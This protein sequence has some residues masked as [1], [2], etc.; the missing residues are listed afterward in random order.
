MREWL[1]ALGPPA[2]SDA[3]AALRGELAALRADAQG[4]GDDAAV[5]RLDEAEGRLLLWEQEMR[6]VA[7]AEALVVEAEQLAA[8]TSIDHAKLPDR[9]QALDRSIRTPA[10]T[11]RFEAAL[12][13]IEQRRLAQIHA[14]RAADERGAATR[15]RAA[16]HGRAGARRR[17]AAGGARS[18][19]RDQGPQGRCGLLPKPTVQRLGR[20]L[21]QLTELERWES[22]GQQNA[23]VQLCE[24][25]EAVAA[26]FPEAA[27]LAREVQK[28][29][30]EWKALDQ[31]HAGVPKALWERFDHACEKAYAPAARH[32]AEVA[33]QR[34]QARKQR[35]DFIAAAA[36]HAPTLLTESPDWRAIERWLRETDQAWREGGLG[37]VEPDTWKKLDARLKAALAPLRDA[38]GAARDKA[39]LTRQQL[40]DEATALV[41][42]AMDRDAP[43]QVKA[44]QAR[45]QEHAKTMTLAQR[46][47]R[48]LWEQF[49]AACD[50]VFSAREA[51]RKEADGR[52]GESRRALEA[53]CAELEQLARATDKDDQELRRALRELQEQWKKASGGSEP[54]MQALESRFRNARSAV[55]ATLAARARSR[56]AAVWQTLAAKERLCEGLDALVRS[57]ASPEDAAARVARSARAMDGPAGAAGSVGEE[58]GRPARRRGPRIGRARRGRRLR[59]ADRARHAVAAREAARA[60]NGAGPRQSRGVPGAAARAAGPAAAQPLPG[61]D[62]GHRPDAGRSPAGLV[63]RAGRGRR[64][65]PA[66][67]DT[68]AGRD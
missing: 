61:R 38:L 23:R 26:Q 56:E 6:A 62:Q 54:G 5:S 50:A 11:R 55:D 66:A 41:P 37:S 22:F 32:F 33:A 59:R 27:Q 12:M 67:R 43:S 29:R 13:V 48:A 2:T 24:R 40:I 60:R 7:D 28:L 20:L 17:T 31:Q 53:I 68:G 10:L 42:K 63:R 52:K 35:D 30:A 46:D 49:R 3:L 34:K 39:K 57:G 15:T 8:D 18:Y 36:V 51:K 45:W 25:A 4:Y 21:Q 58:D 16:A 9:W 44:I 14:A 47:E 19:R 64:A 1:A 65:R